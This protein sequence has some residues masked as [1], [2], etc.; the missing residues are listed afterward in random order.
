MRPFFTLHILKYK[1]KVVLSTTG[2][3]KIFNF[4]AAPFARRQVLAEWWATVA[5]FVL[6]LG[7]PTR[8]LNP[9]TVNETSEAS[10]L[11]LMVDLYTIC[12]VHRWHHDCLRQTERVVNPKISPLPFGN[13]YFKI[14]AFM[15]KFKLLLFRVVVIVSGIGS[16]EAAILTYVGEISEP[17]LRGTL[18]SFAEI[19][20]Y[21]GFVFMFLLGT[22]TDW[23]T[24]ALISSAVPVLTVALLTQVQNLL[25]SFQTIST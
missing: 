22:L 8:D 16:I 5:T 23:R 7:I 25:C 2:K 10:A 12:T 24:S 1:D 11:L 20:E 4:K 19:A 18:T 15:M 6:I 13:V 3:E 17:R 21:I 9:Y 14:K